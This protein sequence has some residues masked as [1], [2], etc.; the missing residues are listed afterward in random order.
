LAEGSSASE[1]SDGHLESWVCELL[2]GA[3]WMAE[4]CDDSKAAMNSMIVDL[5]IWNLELQNVK[6][7]L[8]IRDLQIFFLLIC[9]L[10]ICYLLIC[11][12]VYWLMLLLSI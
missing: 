1:A 2:T 12:T 7:L 11:L 3:T 8:I 10:L 5:D 4:D 6:L 9:Y